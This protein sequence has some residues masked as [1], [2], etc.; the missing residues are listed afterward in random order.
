[1]RRIDELNYI[2]DYFYLADYFVAIDNPRAIGLHRRPA[3]TANKNPLAATEL[4]ENSGNFK[5]LGKYPTLNYNMLL[6]VRTNHFEQIR[7]D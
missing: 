6:Y 1:V 3:W 2:G 7:K 5:R 4:I